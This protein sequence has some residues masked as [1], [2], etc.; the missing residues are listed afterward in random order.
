M[1]QIGL[2]N[3]IVIWGL[4]ALG[5]FMAM[6]NGF[7]SRVEQHNDAMVAVERGADPAE[8]AEAL[9]SWPDYLPSWLVNLGLDLR[10]GAHLLAEVRVEEAYMVRLEGM[11]PDIRDRLKENRAE[12]GPIR[13][14]PTREGVAELRVRL[15][16]KPEQVDR[17]AE[18]IGEL[19]RPVVSLTGPPSKDIDVDVDRDQIVVTVTEA[20]QAAMDDRT[21]KQTLEI[22]RRR[23]DEVGTREPTIQRQGRDRILIQVPGIGSAE[24]LKEIIG[25]TALLTFQHVVSRTENAEEA[26]GAGNEIIPSMDEEGVH[27]ILERSAVVTGEDLVDAQPAFDQNGRPAVNF[28]FNPVGARAF[29][30]YTAKNIGNP[31]AI[32]LDGEVV[33]APV[34]Q[35]HI[36]GG[37]G[38]ITGNFSVESSTNLAILLRAG[39]LPT[40]LDFLEERTIGPELGAD[41]IEAGKIACI[42][43]FVLVLIFMMLSYGIFGFFAN[44][45]LIVNVALI[46]GLLGSIG[47]TLTLPGIAGIV[48][49]IGMAVDANVLVFER[50]REES[51]TTRGSARAIDVGYEKA[52]SAIIDA[53]IT[54]FITAVILYAMGSGPVR[55]FAITL[56]MGIITSV[57]TAIFVTRLMVIIWY[58]RKRP[59]TVLQGRALRL[60]PK[61]TNWDFFSTKRISAGLSVLL[62][63]VSFAS[64][65]GLGL[66]YGIDFK[67][68]TSVRTQS[69]QPVDIG[70]YRDAIEPLGLGDVTITEVFDPTF[71]PDQNVA[72]IRIQAQEG[73][74]SVSLDV[75]G[76]VKQAL[77]GAVPDIDFT[78]V[79]SVGP[80][81]SGE[82][83]QAAALAI[84]LAIGA[85]LFYIWIR[86]EWQFAA[87]AVAALMHDVILTI[88]V[89]SI[90]RIQFDLAIIAAILTIVG[91]SLNDTVVVFDRVRENLRKYKKRP[92]ADVLNISIN[93]TMSRTVMTSVTTMLALLALY[94]LGGDVIRGFVF[95]MMWGVVVGTYSSVFVASAI[96]L[97]LGVKRDWSRHSA[98]AGTDFTGANV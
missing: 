58:Q 93:E 86:F 61:I 73:E 71:G 40:G 25:T 37:T 42:T 53:N 57:F 91:Y 21:V 52:L 31:F 15:V 90:F 26:V 11:W 44:I 9:A 5:L 84:A 63:I 82:L 49:T 60:V 96:L 12:I 50:I 8:H 80:K 98:K 81:V 70:G 88:G 43:A 17:A 22:V 66:N 95:A 54:T 27:Y 24:E 79:D 64:L 56:G 34:I 45:A 72:M 69:A 85:V 65:A 16:G 94:I 92:L 41:S 38:I 89:F 14:Q 19:A 3:R 20:E 47:A 1:L 46:F 55:G 18:I 33:S 76:S 67:G 87:G 68:G 77:I 30:D 29:G 97:W 74:Q 2:F 7:Y 78:S 39:A 75:I 51:A 62:I 6:P 28:R 48:L 23:I 35:S 10:G 83:I 32:I 59:E 13:L 36:A 4:V